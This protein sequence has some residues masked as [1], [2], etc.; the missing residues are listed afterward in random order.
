[1]KRVHVGSRIRP[2]DHGLFAS[3]MSSLPKIIAVSLDSVLCREHG[4]LYFHAALDACMGGLIKLHSE[5]CKIPFS[6]F[7]SK[8]EKNSYPP[9][10]KHTHA[11]THSLTHTHT[12]IPMKI[13]RHK[14]LGRIAIPR[15][16][17]VFPHLASRSFVTVV[18]LMPAT[19]TH[20]IELDNPVQ[21]ASMLATNSKLRH[22]LCQCCKSSDKPSGAGWRAK[23]CSNTYAQPNQ[24]NHGIF[25]SISVR[26]A[27][28][29]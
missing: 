3:S 6:I 11:H 20:S 17:G 21:H 9:C 10:S 25:W 1:M 4:C 15:G 29:C 8:S 2:L 14:S 28:F 24:P 19:Q 26:L 12:H 16:T 18:I 22:R 27:C 5:K 7:F 13:R 23:F